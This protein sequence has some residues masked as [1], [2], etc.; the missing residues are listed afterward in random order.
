[1]AFTTVKEL[2]GVSSSLKREPGKIGGE[3]AGGDQ[4]GG[5]G[6]EDVVE[7]VVA[8]YLVTVK[9][10]CGDDEGPKS[11][12][13][14]RAACEEINNISF[15]EP[16]GEG[17]L[18]FTGC[19]VSYQG[20]GQDED[21]E[22]VAFFAGKV[23]L[24][25]AGQPQPDGGSPDPG[26]PG[27]G[28]LTPDTKNT[29]VTSTTVTMQSPKPVYNK[30]GDP[31]GPLF[32]TKHLAKI[33][34]IDYQQVDPDD[35]NGNLGPGDAGKIDPNAADITGVDGGVST[36]EVE[37]DQ[38]NVQEEEQDNQFHNVQHDMGP[39]EFSSKGGARQ[40]RTRSWIIG[41]HSPVEIENLGY[42]TCGDSAAAGGKKPVMLTLPDGTSVPSTVPIKLGP[43]IKVDIIP[44]AGGK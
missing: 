13:G 24:T 28:S 31:I 7:E 2:R 21:G 39:A 15:G 18:Y 4:C 32:I 30:C 40:K 19:D 9:G 36:V 5:G 6:G 12:R 43:P 23:A 14:S 42:Y 26:G 29:G 37:D 41:I 10:S 8:E 11:I 17:S 25:T 34:M 27:G 16:G 33:T 20:S 1:M 44:K 35:P 3:K 38:G 22:T